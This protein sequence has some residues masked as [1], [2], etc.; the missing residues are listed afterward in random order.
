MKM[1]MFTM[2]AALSLSAT[3]VF[4]QKE[5]KMVLV[6]DMEKTASVASRTSVFILN[7]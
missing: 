4:A 1:K 3:A 6:L 7:M 5:W 2:L